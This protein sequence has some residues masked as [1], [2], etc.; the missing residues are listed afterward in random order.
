MC[1]AVEVPSRPENDTETDRELATVSTVT[2]AKPVAGLPVGGSSKAP[3][4]SAT[5]IIWLAKAVDAKRT[6]APRNSRKTL[7]SALLVG[8]TL[9]SKYM[10][11]RELSQHFMCS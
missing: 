4:R 11:L 3:L 2:S 10:T 7:M 9:L 1:D 6:T 5:Y 8:R